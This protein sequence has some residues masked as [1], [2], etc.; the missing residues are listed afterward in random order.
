M[1]CVSTRE[2]VDTPMSTVCQ[3][4][5]DLEEFYAPLGA[6]LQAE[7]HERLSIK[8]AVSLPP[9]SLSVQPDSG[10]SICVVKLWDVSP[11]L[12]VVRDS[13]LDVGSEHTHKHIYVPGKKGKKKGSKSVDVGSGGLRKQE[14]MF[15][16]ISMRVSLHAHQTGR[17]TLQKPACACARRALWSH[18][19]QQSS[20]FSRL[21]SLSHLSF[22]GI[23]SMRRAGRC[24]SVYV[25]QKG[26]KVKDVFLHGL[27][28]F[29]HSCWLMWG[30]T[31]T[32]CLK[33]A[34]LKYLFLL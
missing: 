10:H 29:L 17:K 7:W 15:K 31:Y 28:G 34:M 4:D 16:P 5:F 13:E 23:P 22:N 32:I 20:K 25:L 27:Q 21:F 8:A 11:E 6:I 18:V 12:I 24:M 19:V 3:R 1:S 33:Y 26:K 14:M 30:T 2:V 9:P